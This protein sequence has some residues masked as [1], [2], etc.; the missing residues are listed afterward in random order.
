MRATALRLTTERA[1]FLRSRGQAARTVTVTVRMADGSELAKT[2]T[3]PMA[4]AHTDDVRRT[5]YGVL[6]GF[7]LQRARSRRVALMAQT[8]DGGQAPMR[9]R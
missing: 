8:V 1:A 3:L 4:S 6:D 5:V 2:R 9:Q 7:W